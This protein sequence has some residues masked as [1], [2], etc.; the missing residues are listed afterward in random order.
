MSGVTRGSGS[1]ALVALLMM[2][3]MSIASARHHARESDAEAGRFDYYL[4][5]L[6]WSPAFCV[7]KPDS[8]ECNGARRYGFIVHGLWPQNERGWPEHCGD[9]RIPESVA[10][11]IADLM[12]ARQLVYHEWATH[13]SCSGL[14]PEEYFSLVRRAPRW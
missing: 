12:P 6:S 3:V 8:P 5:S 7:Q 10:D 1:A 13:G 14:A 2:G 11:G 9:S 4:L